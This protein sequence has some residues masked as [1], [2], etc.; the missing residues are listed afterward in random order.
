MFTGPGLQNILRAL[1]WAKRLQRKRKSFTGQTGRIRLSRGTAC[2][3][4]DASTLP[5][6][7]AGPV[8]TTTLQLASPDSGLRPALSPTASCNWLASKPT[9]QVI[10]GRVDYHHCQRDRRNFLA[11]ETE[12]VGLHPRHLGHLA[13]DSD[14]QRNQLHSGGMSMPSVAKLN[15]NASAG[16]AA[17]QHLHEP[18]VPGS[19][20]ASFRFLP[21]TWH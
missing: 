12:G 15:G 10:S 3:K 6:S 13:L 14:L 19:L 11:A 7:K 8:R 1:R 21:S 4:P 9:E 5:I 18:L 2:T 20:R 16:E 17:V